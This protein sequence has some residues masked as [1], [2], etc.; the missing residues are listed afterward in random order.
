MKNKFK[1]VK[2]HK[3]FKKINKNTWTFIAIDNNSV[4]MIYFL[5]MCFIIRSE[6]DN[7][8]WLKNKIFCTMVILIPWNLKGSYNALKDQVAFQPVGS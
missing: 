8:S 7:A 6:I 1:Y 4:S 5:E 2:L 3:I